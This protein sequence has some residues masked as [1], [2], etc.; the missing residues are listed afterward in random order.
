MKITIHQPNFIPYL[1]FFDKCDYSDILVIYNSTQFKKN[2]FQNRNRIKGKGG[3]FW[4]TVPVTYTF[5]DKINEVRLN[6]NLDWRSKHLKSI[7]V[8][9]SKSK[10]FNKY[11][12][13][14]KEIYNEDW[15]FLS[16]FNT[17]II[18]LFLE[19]VGIKCK[20][21]LSSDLNIGSKRTEA[22]V[23]MCNRLNGETY[24]S[25]GDG[26]NY[27][28]FDSFANENIKVEFQNYQHP[29]YK[30]NFGEFNPYMC[31]LDLLFNEG[32]NSLKI[33]RA[34]RLYES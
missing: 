24:I 13:M 30:Q 18:K 33:I 14:I 17:R 4:L 32:P 9:Y 28:N 23:D 1:G 5:G 25:G 12:P 31:L 19:E 21:V 34:G 27:I 8:C 7:E 22:L 20:I 10:Y 15:E 16:D 6:N 3:G 2:D 26:K 29:D 11:F